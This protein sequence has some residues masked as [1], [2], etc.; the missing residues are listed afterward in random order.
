MHLLVSP[1]SK[2]LISRLLASAEIAAQLNS[3]LAYSIMILKW[4]AKW[5]LE[6][7]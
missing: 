3:T 7:R 2:V 5:A 1:K 6:R 4:N